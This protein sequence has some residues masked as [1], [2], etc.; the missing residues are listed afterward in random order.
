M[1]TLSSINWMEASGEDLVYFKP[2]GS[3]LSNDTQKLCLLQQV[4]W[5]EMKLGEEGRADLVV[6]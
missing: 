1:N 6:L 3:P 5:D 4:G 2:G